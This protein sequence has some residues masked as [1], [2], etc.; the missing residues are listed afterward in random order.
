MPAKLTECLVALLA[1]AALL[2]ASAVATGPSAGDQQYTDPLSG[3]GGGASHASSPR[4]T[5]PAAPT[6]APSPTAPVPATTTP[7]APATAS[8]SAS[9]A[10]SS[11]APAVRDPSSHA[12]PRTGYDE[13]AGV[14]LGVTLLIGGACLRRAASSP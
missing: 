8:T 3:Q 7:S 6:P 10:S 11:S 13:L 9:S 14:A 2:P 4:P 5:A 1:F 12:L